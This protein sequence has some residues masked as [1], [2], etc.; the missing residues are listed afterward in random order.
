MDR[1]GSNVPPLPFGSIPHV[2]PSR[3]G[4]ENDD[5]TPHV[6]QGLCHL[7]D[8]WP[9]GA[10]ETPCFLLAGEERVQA[11]YDARE[12]LRLVWLQFGRPGIEGDDLCTELT[13]TWWKQGMRQAPCRADVGRTRRDELGRKVARTERRKRQALHEAHVILSSRVTKQLLWHGLPDAQEV[14]RRV[15]FGP[16]LKRKVGEEPSSVA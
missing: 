4:L 14:G 7:P 2:L 10:E 6:G 16:L 8:I 13:Q 1:V 11:S 5:P 3:A 12:F 15:G 9:H